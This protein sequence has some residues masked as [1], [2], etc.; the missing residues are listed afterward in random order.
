MDTQGNFRLQLFEN[1]QYSVKGQVGTIGIKFSGST[2]DLW[3][4]GVREL[5]S[6]AIKLG[7]SETTTPLRFV[8]PLPRARFDRR[9]EWL[10]NIA[11]RGEAKAIIDRIS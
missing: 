11:A 3:D 4:R 5:S 6:K 7:T 9:L 1:A 8:I 2:Q 10:S